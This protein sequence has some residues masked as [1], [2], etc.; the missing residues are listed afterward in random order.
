MFEFVPRNVD[1]SESRGFPH[2]VNPKS[3]D[4]FARFF[5]KL[6][7]P[8]GSSLSISGSEKTENNGTAS[9]V[10]RPGKAA[11]ILDEEEEESAIEAGRR[12]NARKG[13]RKIR[14]EKERMR[15]G[16]EEGNYI[17]DDPRTPIRLCETGEAATRSAPEFMRLRGRR[18]CRGVQ[19]WRR[20]SRRPDW[21]GPHAR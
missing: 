7:S 1:S 13:R 3:G 20:A 11:R 2:R 10:Q 4:S 19:T 16:K 6:S 21:Q 14:E 12:E 15:R 18:G 17:A 9:R 8:A 5:R